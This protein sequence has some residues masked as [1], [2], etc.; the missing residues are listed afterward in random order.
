MFKVDIWLTM[1]TA[2]VM[3]ALVSIV[4]AVGI[5]LWRAM[6]RRRGDVQETEPGG[7]SS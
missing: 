1:W 6:S 7:D 5:L 2:G 4:V 3:L